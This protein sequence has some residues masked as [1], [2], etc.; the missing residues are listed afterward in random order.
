MHNILTC[1]GKG[2]FLTTTEGTNQEL[3]HCEDILDQE[4]SFHNAWL[5]HYLT[6]DVRFTCHAIPVC[7]ATIFS[8][9]L[10]KNT[11]LKCSTETV[12]LDERER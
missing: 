6:L 4:K 10:D 3:G 12:Y 2:E 8:L 11:R 1:V 5:T 9:Y 7:T